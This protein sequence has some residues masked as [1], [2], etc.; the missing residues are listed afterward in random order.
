MKRSTE[1]PVQQRPGALFVRVRV[2][3]IDGDVIAAWR[4]TWLGWLLRWFLPTPVVTVIR[5]RELV[6]NH[7]VR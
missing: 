4:W 1:L 6:L 2:R 5:K 7:E 3:R